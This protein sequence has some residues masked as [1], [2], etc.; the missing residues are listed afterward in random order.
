MRILSTLAAGLLVSSS[1]VAAPPLS[2][3]NADVPGIGNCNAD[4]RYSDLRLRGPGFK[5]SEDLLG[6]ALACGLTKTTEIGADYFH[7]DGRNYGLG[8]TG[9]WQFW[10]NAQG[11]ALALTGRVDSARFAG[12]DDLDYQGSSI[13]LAYTQRWGQRHEAHANAALL[14]PDQGDN[15]LGVSLAYGYQFAPEW[16]ALAEVGKTED[17][18]AV[19]GAGLRWQASRDWQLGLLVNQSKDEGVRARELRL[20][21]RFSF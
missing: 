9:K 15:A 1:V 8:L 11:G 17:L 14:L 16:T 7:V 4:F 5:A 10:N 13:G 3:L 18:A 19:W 2:T 12:S 21:A 20:T 6:L